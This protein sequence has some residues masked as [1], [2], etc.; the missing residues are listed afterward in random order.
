[1]RP[2]RRWSCTP[3]RYD[4]PLC[5][6]E[7]KN[8]LAELARI[9]EE[10]SDDPTLPVTSSWTL[11]HRNVVGVGVVAITPDQQRALDERYGAGTVE[12]LP[13]LTPNG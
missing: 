3:G 6:V 13:L 1:M 10:L 4:G 11:E 2:R 5:L 12:V 7:H 8:S 9:Q